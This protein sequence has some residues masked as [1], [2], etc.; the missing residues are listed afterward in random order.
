MNVVYDCS[1]VPSAVYQHLVEKQHIVSCNGHLAHAHLEQHFFGAP[2]LNSTSLDLSLPT[3][4][5]ME[6][7]LSLED[8]FSLQRDHFPLP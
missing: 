4:M 2:S 8:E 1:I 3:I 7:L 6:H 5:E